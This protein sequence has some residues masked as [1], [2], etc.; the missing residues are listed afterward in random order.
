M[1]N[2][3]KTLRTGLKNNLGILIL[4]VF[5]AGYFL[6][7]HARVV[8]WD[9]MAYTLNARYFLGLQNYFEWL[10]PPLAPLLLTLGGYFFVVFVSAL[11]LFSC[12]KLCR[13]FKMDVLSFY[14]LSLTPYFFVK[15]LSIGTELLTL[16]LLQ[17]M[18]AYLEEGGFFL[19]LAFL[20][21]Y[22]NLVFAPIFLFLRDWRKIAVNVL[23]FFLIISPW[24][25][26]N[27]VHTGNALTS[28]L[29]VYAKE[30]KVASYRAAPFFW[31]DFFIAAWYLVP[32]AVFG[33]FKRKWNK[34]DFLML[35]FFLLCTFSY[36]FTASK[37]PRYLF[38]II[39]PLAYFSQ[40]FLKRAKF[41]NY[42]LIAIL[43]FNIGFA[44]WDSYNVRPAGENVFAKAI[45]FLPDNCMVAS[46][47][48]PQLN[49]YG[50]PSAPLNQ[51]LLSYDFWD[52]YRVVFF[53]NMSSYEQDYDFSRA[54]LKSY[55]VI[56]E[57]TDFIIIGNLNL[58]KKQVPLNKT[59]LELLNDTI[60][61]LDHYSIDIGTWR[62]LFGPQY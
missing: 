60:Y 58:C 8:S 12:F 42:L 16:A 9:F 6:F 48:W 35:V 20:T 19:G 2:W 22:P 36:T 57:D 37:F 62:V 38:Y 61:Q 32:L 24:F 1:M 46:N 55:P 17:L 50:R 28:I 43:L 41:G 33:L 53:F 5:V 13:R 7:Q 51:N 39:L 30:I 56:H 40:Q 34:T 29:D 59:Y 31:G 25:V 15:G 23:L 18:L 3:K 44:C 52:G 45:S 49:Y 27:Y 47:A 21:R 26:Y 11:H 4:F 10:R 14:I 54:F